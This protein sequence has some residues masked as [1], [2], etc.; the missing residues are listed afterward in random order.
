MKRG[1]T[2]ISFDGHLMKA[3]YRM[4]IRPKKFRALAKAART[5]TGHTLDE[6]APMIAARSKLREIYHRAFGTGPNPRVSVLLVPEL[7]KRRSER[8]PVI[9]R[10][11]IEQAAN[12]EAQFRKAI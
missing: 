1:R 10:Q 12:T 6:L 5:V 7:R 4:N 2:A 9:L 8:D 11:Q 3:A